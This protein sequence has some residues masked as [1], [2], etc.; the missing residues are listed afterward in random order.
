MRWPVGFVNSVGK[1]LQGDPAAHRRRER[2]RSPGASASNWELSD[3][4]NYAHLI[5][6]IA[7]W[8]I[9]QGGWMQ[10][11]SNP[12]VFSQSAMLQINSGPV[13]NS[14]NNNQAR[15]DEHTGEIVFDNM[16][17]NV[18]GVTVMRRILVD[19]NEAYVRYIDILKNSGQQDKALEQA[20]MLMTA[21]GGGE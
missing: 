5:Q 2:V 13:N 17:V 21:P 1:N 7:L 3:A 20:R 18:P 8:L 14:N 15:L 10:Q 4:G 12:P 11:R 6:T 19:Q 16:T 9:Y